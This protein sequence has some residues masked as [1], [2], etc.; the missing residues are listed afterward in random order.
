[1]DKYYV[2][3]RL[4]FATFDC[5]LSKDPLQNQLWRSYLTYLG[6]FQSFHKGRNLKVQ[7]IPYIFKSMVN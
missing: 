5:S 6:H 2:P 3:S 7:Q 1:M 4:N